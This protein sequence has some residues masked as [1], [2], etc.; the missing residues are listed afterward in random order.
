MEL[1]AW[2][3]LRRKERLEEGGG[4]GKVP[5]NEFTPARPQKLVTANRLQ[6]SPTASTSPM[7]NSVTTRGWQMQGGRV[8]KDWHRKV[9]GN[10]DESSDLFAEPRTPSPPSSQAKQPPINIYGKWSVS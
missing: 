2:R 6:P 10:L 8:R 7:A 4:G 5:E 9:A 3:Q 1:R